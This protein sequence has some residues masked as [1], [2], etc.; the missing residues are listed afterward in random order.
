M[1][2]PFWSRSS[3]PRPVD[4]DAIVVGGGVCG[5]SAALHLRR[6]GL[7]V[8]VFERHTPGAGASSR[9]AGFLMR[10]LAENY[11]VARDTLGA[12]LARD[13]WHW[14]EE[15]LRGLQDEGVATLGS[16]RP[17][18]SCLLALEQDEADELVE[19]AGLLQ[20]DGFGVLLTETGSDSAWQS[21]LPLVG[22][23]N[24]G[25]ATVNPAEL[26][27]LLASKL[28]S[29]SEG[30][31]PLA[32]VVLAGEE[33][34]RIEPASASGDGRCVVASARFAARAPHVLVCTNAYAGDLLPGLERLVRPNRGQMLALQA[35]G[36]TLD[37]AYYANRGHEYIRQTT[38]GTIVVGGCRNQ[39]AAAERTSDNGTT[40]EVQGAI[41]AFARLLLDRPIRVVARWAGT[42]G[43]SPDGMPLVGPVS[44][45]GSVWFCGGFTGHGMS[46]AYRTSR[47]AVSAMLGGM[48]A[49]PLATSFA[50]GRANSH[51]GSTPLHG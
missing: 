6:R 7:R 12:A 17:M 43:F 10:G 50:L 16:Y 44:E 20:A 3:Q 31:A 8:V 23:V 40:D 33:V 4:A 28:G 11:R 42:M 25:D 18:P 32:N 39:F 41:E 1:T 27:G 36:A 47:G 22:L 14:S 19:S 29:A 35:E 34:H 26:V 49:D 13:V 45:D 15:N 37:Y 24:L 51:A 5:L 46:L 48:G 9:N 2:V 38:D 21:K 30:D